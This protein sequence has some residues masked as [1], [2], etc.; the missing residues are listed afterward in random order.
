MFFDEGEGAVRHVFP[1]GHAAAQR[2]TAEDARAEH[3]GIEAACN[4]R[5]HRGDELGRVL[6]V[7]VDHDDH[8]GI[9]LKRDAVAVLLVRAVA[10]VR[11]VYMHD[12]AGQLA[13]DGHGVI[14]RGVVDHHDDVHDALRHDLVVGLPQGLRR[15]VGRHDHG[16]FFS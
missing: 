7:G 15:V 11:G 13:R 16:H 4:H 3:A 6:V 10:A 9:L 12:H 5:R 2:L 14:A 8:V 1:P